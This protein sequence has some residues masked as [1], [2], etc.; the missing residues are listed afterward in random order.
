MGGEEHPGVYEITVKVDPSPEACQVHSQP[1]THPHTPKEVL[2]SVFSFSPRMKIDN[3]LEV[4]FS[5]YIFNSISHSEI[6]M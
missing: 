4:F 3:G 6:N 1:S 5:I 2:A